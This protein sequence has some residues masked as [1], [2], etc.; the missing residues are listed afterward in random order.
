VF[1]TGYDFDSVDDILPF[2]LSA[3]FLQND[4]VNLDFG[5]Y[6][7]ISI[8]GLATQDASWDLVQVL[9]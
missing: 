2:L 9:S 6:G 4:I 1:D 8:V 5:Q 7:L 3:E